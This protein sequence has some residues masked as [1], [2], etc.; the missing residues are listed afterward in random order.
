MIQGN[1]NKYFLEGGGLKKKVK[2]SKVCA[3]TIYE[4]RNGDKRYSSILSSTSALD[5]VGGQ[6]HAPAA[7]P[8]AT[9]QVPNFV[10]ACVGP[11]TELDGCGK[12]RP[13]PG[14]DPPN[15]QPVASR[16]TNYAATARSCKKG[17]L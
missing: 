1:Q 17:H 14:F 2:E 7:L 4:V 3:K 11:R 6:H 9:D 16:H 8:P 5:G 12:S 15:F 13:P 10:A